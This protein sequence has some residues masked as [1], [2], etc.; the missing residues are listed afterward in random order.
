MRHASDGIRIETIT[1][2]RVPAPCLEADL[3]HD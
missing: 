2:A 1:H 3:S